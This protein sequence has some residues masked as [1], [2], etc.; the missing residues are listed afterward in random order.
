MKTM[1]TILSQTY[2]KYVN[3]Y[4]IVIIIIVMFDTHFTLTKLFK[5]PPC[6]IVYYIH[7]SC[8]NVRL[9]T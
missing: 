6:D 5:Y 4:Y 7:I 3:N 1:S 9:V 8:S 2:V